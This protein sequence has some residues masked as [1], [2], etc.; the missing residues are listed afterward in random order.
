LSFPNSA[1]YAPERLG[2]IKKIFLDPR[3]AEKTLGWKTKVSFTE[4]LKKTVE[5]HKQALEV[6]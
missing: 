6:A 1:N 3:K 2:E 5:W 4:G